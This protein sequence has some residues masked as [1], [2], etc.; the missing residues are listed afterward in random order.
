MTANS[1]CEL[2][3]FVLCLGLQRLL[4]GCAGFLR[5]LL[6]RVLS[7]LDEDELRKF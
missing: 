2:S 5:M 3:V 6:L 1:L 4:I 7:D